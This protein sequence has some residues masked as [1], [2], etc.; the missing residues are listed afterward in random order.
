MA[1]NEVGSR[2]PRLPGLLQRGPSCLRDSSVSPSARSRAAS[3]N[4]NSANFKRMPSGSRGQRESRARPEGL[5]GRRNSEP[6]TKRVAPASLS[7][8]PCRGEHCRGPETIPRA[9]SRLQ[10]LMSPEE[11]TVASR[12]EEPNDPASCPPPCC[13]SSKRLLLLVRD[14][15]QAREGQA[16]IERE[17]EEERLGSTEP[18][19]LASRKCKRD[20]GD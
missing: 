11:V 12:S 20:L 18:A 2:R 13:T 9:R 16:S 14:D 6:G 17:N 3:T 4:D 7:K 1:E 5:H 19:K 10:R 8:R 15:P